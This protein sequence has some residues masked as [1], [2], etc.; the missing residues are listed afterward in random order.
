[1]APKLSVYR[2]RAG[3]ASAQGSRAFYTEGRP[4]VFSIRNL[5]LR[6]GYAF[7]F[8]YIF[9][10]QVG[11]PI[12]ADPLLL[13]M[14]ALTGDHLYKFWPSLAIA[15]MAAITG[16]YIWYE[17]GRKRGRR[18]L[19]LLC[20]LSIEPD[21]CV[22][23][24][25][26]AFSKRGAGALLFAKFVPGMG[27]VSMPLAGMVGMPRWHFLLADAAGSFLWSAAYLTAGWL[28]YRQVDAAILYLGLMGRRAGL[29]VVSLVAVYL[30]FK[31]FQR[32]RFIRE[33]R[34]NRLA[35]A[36]LKEILDA[37]NPVTVIDLRHPAE[38]ERDGV[39]LP[40]A[41]IMRPEELRSRSGE[42]PRDQETILYCT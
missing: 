14:G 16:D 7:L 11:T 4:A 15:V 12:P 32:W 9:A 39:K 31:Y 37:G 10:V 22:R 23:K 36:R 6:H 40:G 3:P 13:V 5:L 24:T 30:A 33:L 34:I 29:V 21:T 17:L 25:E 27:L 38:I 2:I 42:I 20:K 41:R 26:S 1:M 28:L 8:C 18:L 35:P 19:A